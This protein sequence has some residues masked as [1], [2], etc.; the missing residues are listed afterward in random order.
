LKVS[1]RF[2][3]AEQTPLSGLYVADLIREAGFPAGVVN[4][5]PG[6][7]PTAGAAIAGHPNVDKVTSWG[8]LS[9]QLQF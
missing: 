5:V 4:V 9:M 8:R 6:Y 2:Q 1:I 3:L 7:G